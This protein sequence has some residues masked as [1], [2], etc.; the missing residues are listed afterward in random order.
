[1][2]ETDLLRSTPATLELGQRA[3]WQVIENTAPGVVD[4][5]DHG[6]STLGQ[7][8]AAKVMLAGQITEQCNDIAMNRS[9]SMANRNVP[10][11][12]AGAPVA[13]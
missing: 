4:R 13:A 12:A 7:G 6:I 8:K 3:L 9:N 11:D 2:L 5:D 1:M 10:V